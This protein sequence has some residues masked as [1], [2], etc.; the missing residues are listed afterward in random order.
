MRN[1]DDRLV[2]APSEFQRE[3]LK[4]EIAEARRLLDKI[5]IKLSKEKFKLVSAKKLNA[6]LKQE[7]K[8]SNQRL[9]AQIEALRKEIALLNQTLETKEQEAEK[10]DVRIVDLG[11]KLNRA[12]ASKVQE[13]ARFRSE[14]F[15]KLQ[16]V[17]K[18]RKDIEI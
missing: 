5:I 7:K 16:E 10:K 8:L 2:E 3:K 6:S 18:N 17:L 1:E 11:K 14:F 13:L 12:L 4:R 15:G 9:N